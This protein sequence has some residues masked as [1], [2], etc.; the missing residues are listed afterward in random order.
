ML[1][2]KS[3]ILAFDDGIHEKSDLFHSQTHDHYAISK[4]KTTS[5]IGSIEIDGRDATERILEIFDQNPHRR[6]IQA[7]LIDS[8]TMGGFNIP[9]AFEIHQRSKLPVILIPSNAP[10]QSIVTVYQSLFPDREKEIDI[11]K[12]LPLISS[13]EVRVNVTPEITKRVYFHAIGIEVSEIVEF[14]QFIT[15][16]SA[17]PEPLRLAHLIASQ[18]KIEQPGN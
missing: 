14:L 6:E 2:R 10:T 3:C 17:I 8:P 15:H 12:K 9:D 7:I 11:L 13:I 5:L 1:K 18:S 4:P 16:F